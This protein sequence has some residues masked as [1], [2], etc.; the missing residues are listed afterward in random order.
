M[1]RTLSCHLDPIFPVQIQTIN[2]ESDDEIIFVEYKLENNN[3]DRFK[4][5]SDDEEVV[6]TGFGSFLER[7]TWKRTKK[8]HTERKVCNAFQKI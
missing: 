7:N 8:N 3:G 2:S 6:V 4:Q 1:D 5:E